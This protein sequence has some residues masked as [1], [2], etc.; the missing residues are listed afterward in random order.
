MKRG[1]LCGLSSFHSVFEFGLGESTYIADHVGVPR[2]AGVDSDA[3]WVAQARYQVAKH[4]RFSFADI[5]QTRKWGSPAEDL[6]KNIW[7]Y[8]IAPLMMEPLPFDVYLADGRWRV[9]C[10]LISF[11]HASARRNTLP[12]HQQKNLTDTLV[13]I[14]DC[15]RQGL[16]KADAIFQ[17]SQPPRG[18]NLCEYRRLPNTTDEQIMDMWLKYYTEVDAWFT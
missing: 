17:V 13:L 14:H 5:G 18:L 3:T 6:A 9:G 1:C 2:Y 12:P 10:M 4:F 16:H 8:Q 7:N 15:T 11:L